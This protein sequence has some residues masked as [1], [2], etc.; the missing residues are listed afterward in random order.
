MGAGAQPKIW[1]KT[2]PPAIHPRVSPL[3]LSIYNRGQ[4]SSRGRRRC[5]YRNPQ[6]PASPS[7]GVR[8]RGAAPASELPRRDEG[9]GEPPSFLSPMATASAAT[10]SALFRG[11]A[12]CGLWCGSLWWANTDDESDPIHSIIPWGQSRHL[13]ER[14]HQFLCSDASFFFLFLCF[15]IACF[16]V[17]WL[18]SWGKK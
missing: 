12:C 8:A 16:A 14:T 18:A 15:S 5:C 9:Q 1:P 4:S 3:A 11:V 6:P 10:C 13:S 17:L 2:G 7:H